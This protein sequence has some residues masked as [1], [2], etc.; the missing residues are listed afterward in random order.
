MHQSQYQRWTKLAFQI[1][2]SYNIISWNESD[3]LIHDLL[4]L[5]EKEQVNP[6]SLKEVTV[7]IADLGSSCWVVSTCSIHAS[8]LKL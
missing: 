6:Y 3:V 1:L 2:I 5:S 7:K 8:I 4:F